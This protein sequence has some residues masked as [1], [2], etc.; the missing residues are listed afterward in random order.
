MISVFNFCLLFCDF[1]KL[2]EIFEN[3]PLHW[4]LINTLVSCLLSCELTEFFCET[5]ILTE[6]IWKSFFKSYLLNRQ[7]GAFFWRQKTPKMRDILTKIKHFHFPHLIPITSSTSHIENI[8][9]HGT[10]NYSSTRLRRYLP[11][12][13][14]TI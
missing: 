7:T 4:Q 6:I 5:L 1:F 2:T 10:V 13:N 12:R 8:K 9:F 14:K 3:C 11:T